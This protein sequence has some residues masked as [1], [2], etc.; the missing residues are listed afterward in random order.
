ML[1]YTGCELYDDP[2]HRLLFA[3][4][5][6]YV[7]FSLFNVVILIHDCYLICLHDARYVV[8][9]SSGITKSMKSLRRCLGFQIFVLFSVSN[10]LFPYF[11]FFILFFIF[12]QMFAFC[13][14][15]L[16]VFLLVFFRSVSPLCSNLLGP[17]T[18][19]HEYQN[20][21]PPRPSI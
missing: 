12:I 18:A 13:L 17:I 4:Y 3:I 19:T 7:K 6:A 10:F 8:S 9:S 2:I 21:G 1:L 15:L 14:I 5:K 11:I 20:V 16:W